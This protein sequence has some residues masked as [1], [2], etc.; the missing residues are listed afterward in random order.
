MTRRLLLLP[1]VAVLLL[2]P[3]SG[4]AAG[5]Y[6][7]RS[8][9]FFDY[10]ETIVLNSG[11]GDY[12]GYTENQFI[13]GSIGVGTVYPNGTAAASYQNTG[14]WEN[15]QGQSNPF[16]AQGN[17]TFSSSTFHYV[18]GTD[19]QSG[20]VNPYVWFYVDNQ[21][22]PGS[23]FYI[24]NTAMS[25][26]STNVSY[27]NPLSP[28]GYVRTLFGEGNGSFSRNDVYGNF[29][30]S[31]N[32]KTY[33]DPA[34]GFIVGYVYTEQ[35][36]NSTSGF[37]WTDVLAVT[38]TSYPLTPAAAPPILGSS[39]GFESFFLF[40]LV[41]AVVI[42][43]LVIGIALVLR[44]KKLPQHSAPGPVPG[45]YPSW[46]PPPLQFGGAGAAPQIV[47][48]E[49]IKVPCRYCGSLIDPAVK[50]CPNCGAPR[51]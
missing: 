45:G 31:Y 24:L 19:N 6:L 35:D 22:A 2:V 23:S 20:Y 48:R 4:A 1:L 51:T 21:L 11:F 49:T 18:Q 7:P 29:V 9:D 46:N 17:F 13:N 26:V 25:L 28:T 14:H 33:F 15:N 27:G 16:S 10:H 44:R 43:L 42:P 12:Q 41:L 30:A 36:S 8:G 5:H 38:A 37:T 47:L 3:T 32:W 40:L 39:T 50:A 34:T